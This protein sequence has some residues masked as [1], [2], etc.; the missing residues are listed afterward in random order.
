MRNSTLLKFR[1]GLGDAVQFTCVL[2]HLTRFRSDT[3]FDVAA[4]VGKDS[5]MRGLCRRVLV[6]DRDE[7]N[8][9]EYSDV[10]DIGWWESDTETKA[11]K[12]LKDDFGIQPTDGLMRYQI[13]VS[14]EA[15]E[16]AETYLKSICTKG[17]A[18][19]IHYEGNT[20]THKK[21]LPHATIARLC[22]QLIE[23]NLTPVILDWD[24]RSALPDHRRIFCPAA[25]SELWHGM[26]TGDAELI[27]ALIKCSVLMIGIDSGPL[28]IAGA[29][30]TPTL[31]IW[32]QHHPYR[33]FDL[34]PNVI[35]LLP[36]N[37]RSMPPAPDAV[38]AA[39]FERKYR[40]VE[41]T[42]F[43]ETIVEVAESMLAGDSYLSIKDK[44]SAKE[45]E[46]MEWLPGALTAMGYDEVYYE[47]HKAAG[48][49][50]LHYGD[51]QRDYGRW[52]V[53]S[54]GL[55]GKTVLDVGC[56]CGSIVRGFG[57]A[58]AYVSGCDI[59]EHMIR[60][61]K[62]TYPDMKPILHCCDAINL[63]LW[64]DS[65]FDCIHSAQSAEHWRPDHVPMILKELL[66]VT[67]P[68]GLLWVSLDTQELYDRQ[69]RDP[70]VEDKTHVCIQPMA[71]WEQQLVD[72]GWAIRRDLLLPMRDYDDS[73]LR[74]YDWDWFAASKNED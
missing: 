29:T 27:A 8:Q 18:V 35:H 42:R 33:F 49:D 56:A 38:T 65:T 45:N 51:W 57:E 12:C 67:K 46:M 13:S 66:R 26:G 21:N 4:L 23:K 1:H 6:F 60:L 36:A 30:S 2:Q 17:P 69:N 63:H 53:G 28:H 70:K 7:I 14:A 40:F 5:A 19:V 59:S 52:F 11:R 16:T 9:S 50:Y 25:G 73:F 31:A 10:R 71:W 15:L 32:T 3:D 39:S 54:L 64:R 41:Y 47:Q 58:G 48:L 34:C 55:R 62:K 20:S 43:N 22:E 37:W 61:A 74:R 24:G 68:G 44:H 72:A